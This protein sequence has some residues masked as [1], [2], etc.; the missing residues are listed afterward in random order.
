MTEPMHDTTLSREPIRCGNTGCVGHHPANADG[1]RSLLTSK[2]RQC[3]DYRPAEPDAD[4][5][6]DATKMVKCG[7]T[8][9]ENFDRMFFKG[10]RVHGS[11]GVAACEGYRPAERDADAGK[12]TIVSPYTST[13]LAEFA[14]I[15][16]EERDQA[17]AELAQIR[18]ALELTGFTVPDIDEAVYEY[19]PFGASNKGQWFEQWDGTWGPTYSFSDTP[20]YLTRRRRR[21]RRAPTDADAV[22]VPRRECWVLIDNQW[23]EAKLLMVA[24][25][26]KNPY[27]VMR[28]D[29]SIGWYVG[30]YQQCEIEVEA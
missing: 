26:V 22:A 24:A 19:S 21:V 1:C 14:T 2:I 25:G 28:T 11:T 9:C 30:W 27:L 13:E 20:A 16:T 8:E 15:R 6:P 23:V 7:N 29:S 5:I 12:P 4:H 3:P 10:C 18:R 17:R